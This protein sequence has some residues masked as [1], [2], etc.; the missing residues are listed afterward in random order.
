MKTNIGLKKNDL[1]HLVICMYRL[2][3]VG[4]FKLK[5][6]GMLVSEG[7][8]MSQL[9]KIHTDERGNHMKTNKFLESL[10]TVAGILVFGIFI[11]GVALLVRWLKND[12]TSGLMFTDQS[13]MF[14][15]GFTGISMLGVLICDT[16]IIFKKTAI[17]IRA[18]AYGLVVY[19]G[20]L[21]SLINTPMNPLTSV[22][23][24]MGLSLYYL[25]VCTLVTAAW[26]AFKGLT[27]AKSA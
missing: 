16:A 6:C 13:M 21:V 20:I 2:V 10:R 22:S 12:T 26:Y 1:Y 27:Q 19:V 18:M 5:G 4:L 9:K 23:K 3:A 14:L 8:A 17:K 24:F 15:L 7:R 11:L 25:V